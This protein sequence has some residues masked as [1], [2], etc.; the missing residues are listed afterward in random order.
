MGF[1]GGLP[2]KMNETE[3]HIALQIISG[4]GRIT[5]KRLVKK[6]GSALEVW[7]NRHELECLT[8]VP[9]NVYSAIMAG[10]AMDV[11]DRIVKR[12]D[13]L[14]GWI[15]VWGDEDYPPR[16]AGIYD[17]PFVIYGIGSRE[18][19]SMDAVA[20]VGSRKATGYGRQAAERLA[21]GL[22]EH[23]IAVVSGL[24]IGIDAAA[25]SAAV[26]SGGV[27]VAVKGCGLDIPYPR[28]NMKLA[29]SI[30]ERG[31]IISEFP[32]GTEPEPRNFPVRNR[33]IS[34][35]SLGVVVVEAAEK[36]GSLITASMAV[37]HGREI[38]A[39]PGSIFSPMSRGVH[40][41]ARQGAVLVASVDDVLE[42]IKGIEPFVSGSGVATAVRPDGL[43]LSGRSFTDEERIVL[44]ALSDYPLHIDDLASVCNMSIV[45]VSALLVQ[46]ELDDVV[47]AMPG[48]MYSLA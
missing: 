44:D 41:L 24:A 33:I 23:G 12:M 17:P 19:L 42:C 35:L 46:L 31:A 27:T 16:L 34:G 9:E 45:D 5:H 26:S 48:Q 36:S 40:W 37:E 38:M 47:R 25:H 22:S 13:G 11:V 2:E 14:A 6:F 28:S 15:M 10:P 39:V 43:S 4:L 32:A 20:M 30:V 8:W 21:S 3:A 29:E 1:A 7:E 18:A